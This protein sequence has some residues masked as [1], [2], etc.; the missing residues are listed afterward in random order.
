MATFIV[1][2]DEKNKIATKEPYI[3]LYTAATPNGFKVTILLELLNLDYFVCPIDIRSGECKEEWYLKFNP[4]GRIPSLAH[5]TADGSITYI[6]E[7]AAILLYLADKFDKDFKYSFPHG[8]KEYYEVLEWIFF[9][10]SGLGPMEGQLHWFTY[11]APQKDEFAIERYLKETLRLFGVLEERL[12][13]N[14]SDFLV[15]DHL[16]LADI[17]AYPW[18]NGRRMKE[19]KNY[20]RLLKWV[21][22][23]SEITEV[24]KAC[25]VPS[26]NL[27]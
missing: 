2:E 20:P 9:Q 27:N 18:I 13:R 4:N 21:D 14:N 26:S 16:T 3:K 8:T 24:K 10:M 22:A 12:K 6:N 23:I 11:Y 15:S 7:S 25:K 5:A 1:S 19:L 17:V